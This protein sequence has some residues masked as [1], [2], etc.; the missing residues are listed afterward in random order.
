M[1]QFVLVANGITNVQFEKAMEIK[2]QSGSKVSLVPQPTNNNGVQTQ[3]MNSSKLKP[4][5]EELLSI[6]RFEWNEHG[7]EFGAKIV[8]ALAHHHQ[9]EPAV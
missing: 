6:V 1:A 7:A 3:S 8:H 4:D 2:I 9:P 5:A